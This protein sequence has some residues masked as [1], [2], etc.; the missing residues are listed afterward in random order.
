MSHNL[1][2]GPGREFDVIRELL[3][4]WGPRAVGIGDDAAVLS[5]ARGDA[6]VASVDAVVEGRHFRPGW[7]T[8]RQLGYRAVAAALSDIA[9]MAA[10]PVG[11]LIA[12]AAPPDLRGQLREIA[13]GIGEA[14]DFARTHV[15]GGNLTAANELSITTTVLGSAFDPLTRSGARAG[16]H[17]YVT[18]RLGGV[19]AALHALDAGAPVEAFCHRFVR[20][21]PRLAEARWLADRGATAAIDVSDGLVADMRHLATASGASVELEGRDVPCFPGVPLTIALQSGEEYELLV[22][23]PETLAV[24]DFERRFGLP[25]TRIG[26]FVRG[27]AGAIDLRGVA[28]ANIAGHDHFSV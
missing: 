15:V 17:V 10:R 26:R 27:V 6:L 1:S 20:P 11:V 4:T 24:E 8:P 5:V 25:L 19:A 28:V 7:L 3:D 2:L 9:A 13:A 21:I 23:G 22:T 14:V 16:D 18:G 12:I